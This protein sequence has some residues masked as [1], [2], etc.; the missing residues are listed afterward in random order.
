MDDVGSV[1]MPQD[2]ARKAFLEDPSETTLRSWLRI[3]LEYWF[4]LGNEADTMSYAD[5]LRRAEELFGRRKG[6]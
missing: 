5:M 6:R 4:I 2:A 1:D 3:E